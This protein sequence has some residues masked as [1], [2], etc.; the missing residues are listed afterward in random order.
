MGFPTPL[1][2]W[3]QNAKSDRLFSILRDPDGVIA[4]YIERAEL[5]SLIARQRSGQEDCT[6]RIWRLL[7]F[8]LW[9]DIFLTGRRDRHESL[10]AAGATVNA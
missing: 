7:N 2:S 8:Q 10:L 9:G 3:L 6:D 1:R 5:D 4:P